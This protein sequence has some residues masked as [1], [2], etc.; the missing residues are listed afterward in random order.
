MTEQA[1]KSASASARPPET[2]RGWRWLR[3]ASVVLA[4]FVALRVYQQRDLPTG[5][6]PA[7]RDVT[8]LNGNPVTLQSYRGQAVMLHFWATWCGVCK[9]EQHNVAAL[10]ANEKVIAVASQSGSAADVAAY[11]AAHPLGADVIVD[12]SGKLAA[13]YGVHAFPT[14][15]FLDADSMIR[16]AEIGYTSELGMRVRLWLARF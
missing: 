4:L 3:E 14:S 5:P 15:F 2:P 12:S 7:L 1:S 8:D 10:A 16:H 13:R 11:L 9:A 6:A